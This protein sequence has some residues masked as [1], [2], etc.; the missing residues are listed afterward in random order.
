M[1]LLKDYTKPVDY[2]VC[3]QDKTPITSYQK[4]KNILYKS[5]LSEDDLDLFK[6]SVVY[7]FFTDVSKEV[8]NKLYNVS[9]LV[10]FVHQSTPKNIDIVCSFSSKDNFH[11]FLTN[12]Q[13]DDYLEIVNN[14]VEQY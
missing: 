12:N 7:I 10:Y 2:F 5:S 4:Y 1:T 11:S 6:D 14:L 8:M 13:V 3:P 9:N